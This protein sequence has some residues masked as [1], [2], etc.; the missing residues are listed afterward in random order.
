VS[1]ELPEP[2]HPGTTVEP[3]DLNPELARKN[4]LAAWA[5]FALFLVLAAGVV[6]VALIYNAVADY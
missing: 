6:A 4:V 2:G 1:E 3:V 5:L